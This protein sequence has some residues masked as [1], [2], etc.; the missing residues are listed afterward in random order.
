M[1]SLPHFATV[2]EIKSEIQK[3]GIKF[4]FIQ[5]QITE[6]QNSK[7]IFYFLP[8][9]KMSAEHI[10]VYRSS[11]VMIQRLQIMEG[12][13]CF[14]GREL[15][16]IPKQLTKIRLNRY[17]N[18]SAKCGICFEEKYDLFQCSMGCSECGF[19]NCMQCQAKN[20]LQTQLNSPILKTSVLLN[21]AGCR[22]EYAVFLPTIC[23]FLS[24]S[25]AHI[26]K[27]FN[28][29][30]REI[31]SIL[32]K[33]ASEMDLKQAKEWSKMLS[34]YEEQFDSSKCVHCKTPFV[35]SRKK[36]GACSRVYY[37]SAKCQK[38]DWSS[39]KNDCKKWR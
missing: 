28:E 21:C 20:A 13:C 32:A 9:D 8:K 3:N 24:L 4:Q 14:L 37:C 34:Y 26:E 25:T 16:F 18:P 27:D 10:Q 19:Q 11:A 1:P 22:E 2:D 29:R 17:I 36:C 5:E 31:I 23:C 39:H 12:T 7:R 38:C 33:H 15:D 30:E 6:E 35:N